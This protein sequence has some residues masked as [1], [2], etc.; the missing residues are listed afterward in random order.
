MSASSSSQKRPLSQLKAVSEVI[1]ISDEEQEV[2]E[3]ISL[4]VDGDEMVQVESGKSQTLLMGAQKLMAE[5]FGENKARNQLIPI[6]EIDDLHLARNTSETEVIRLA[7]L[8][9]GL[10]SSEGVNFWEKVKEKVQPN[11]KE[12]HILIVTASPAGTSSSKKFI[13]VEGSHRIA[14]AYKW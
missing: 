14:L 6:D 2:D 4:T 9:S 8:I 10:K 5:Y 13:L 11:N 7:L 12:F 1:C 3:E